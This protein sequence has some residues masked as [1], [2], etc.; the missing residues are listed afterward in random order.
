MNSI[1]QILTDGPESP[2]SP[3]LPF[4][5]RLPGGPGGPGEEI[6]LNVLQYRKRQI[7]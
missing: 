4:F 5:P 3:F 6:N 1:Y 7:P 2:V